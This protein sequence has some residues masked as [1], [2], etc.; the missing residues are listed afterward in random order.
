MRGPMVGALGALG[1][2][3]PV[4]VKGS[5]TTMRSKPGPNSTPLSLHYAHV[6]APLL[7]SLQ[8]LTYIS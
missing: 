6:A 4:P 3:H 5:E 8:R 7:C 1:A 2:L